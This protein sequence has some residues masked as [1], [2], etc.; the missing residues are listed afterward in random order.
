MSN[1]SSQRE[2]VVDLAKEAR[3]HQIP[4]VVLPPG[5]AEFVLGV[6][7]LHLAGISRPKRGEG[8]FRGKDHVEDRIAE[9][10]V[11]TRRPVKNSFAA[12]V[13]DYAC[14]ALLRDADEEERL[15][16]QAGSPDIAAGEAVELLVQDP[17]NPGVLRPTG[18]SRTFTGLATSTGARLPV[19]N[20]GS[21]D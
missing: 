17:K 12:E 9:V 19:T 14:A 4:P 3:E 2:A 10:A 7:T 15:R 11:F 16:H 5:Q 8:V 21:P 6:Q 18:I 1:P 13:G 20:E